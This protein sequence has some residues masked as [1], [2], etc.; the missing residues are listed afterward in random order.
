[1]NLGHVKCE[2]EHK[3][4]ELFQQ[5]QQEGVPM[6]LHLKR[7]GVFTCFPQLSSSTPAWSTSLAMM[8]CLQE[9][10]NIT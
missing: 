10:E 5:M 2:Q 6:L 7:V 4:L 1:M 8:G 3:A 9:A